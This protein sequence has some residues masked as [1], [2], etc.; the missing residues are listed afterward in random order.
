[1]SIVIC[2]NYQISIN[3][4]ELAAWIEQQSENNYSIWSNNC[5]HF[6]M[7]FAKKFNP[8]EQKSGLS[9]WNEVRVKFWQ[10]AE[11]LCTTNE[12]EQALLKEIE[13]MNSFNF[14]YDINELGL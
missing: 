1:M 4:K 12:V 10:L 3:S 11:T 5:I 8:K 6:A 9:I 2:K 14:T 7:D 13:A